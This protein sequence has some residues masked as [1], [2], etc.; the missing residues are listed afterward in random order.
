MH[1][2][3]KWGTKLK[4]CSNAFLRNYKCKKALNVLHNSCG[5]YENVATQ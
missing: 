3:G 1:K 2:L 4:A 5:K